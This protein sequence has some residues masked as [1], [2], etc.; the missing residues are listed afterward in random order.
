MR[1]IST[2]A[3]LI[4][5]WVSA[6][7]GRSADCGTFIA[8]ISPSG[9]ILSAA[10]FECLYGQVAVAHLALSP[11]CH[12]LSREF[13]WY[14]FHYPFRELQVERILAPVSRLNPPAQRIVTHLG[15]VLEATLSPQESPV[16]YYTMTEAQ[17]RWLSLK[18]P[19]HGQCRKQS[20]RSDLRDAER[21]E[22][23]ELRGSSTGDGG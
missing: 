12:F 16:L 7:L 9:E 22:N 14:I 21:T 17:C 2:E 20:H 13:L 8:D 15:F 4:S 11:S 10:W 6:A 5:P 18:E 23:S 19:Q 3:E 1:R